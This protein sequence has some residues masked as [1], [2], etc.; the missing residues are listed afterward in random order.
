MEI[1]MKATDMVTPPFPIS[2]KNLGLCGGGKPLRPTRQH[3]TWIIPFTS[4]LSNK[5][6]G[7]CSKQKGAFASTPG[8]SEA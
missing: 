4:G 2:R 1:T 5:A 6:L 7:G 3:V 8:T